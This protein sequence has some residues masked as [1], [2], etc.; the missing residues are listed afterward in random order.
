M[1]FFFLWKT[2]HVLQRIAISLINYYYYY[3]YFRGITIPLFREV[4]V[5]YQKK[6]K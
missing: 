4:I 1:S 3:Y 5:C 6:K 2:H